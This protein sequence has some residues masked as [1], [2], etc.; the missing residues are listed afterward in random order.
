MQVYARVRVRTEIKESNISIAAKKMQAP[1]LLN[2]NR[3]VYF[4]FDR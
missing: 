4:A 1:S 2:W 3:L